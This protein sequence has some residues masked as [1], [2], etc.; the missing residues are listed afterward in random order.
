MIRRQQEN[1]R[2][3]VINF[4]EICAVMMPMIRERNTSSEGFYAGPHAFYQDKRRKQLGSVLH[5]S[6]E[7]EIDWVYTKP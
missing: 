1:Y 3:D 4:E 5:V 2:E 6:C 7:R